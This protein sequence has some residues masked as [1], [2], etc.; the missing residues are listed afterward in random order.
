MLD[1][2]RA[3]LRHHEFRFYANRKLDGERTV[4]EILLRIDSPGRG[5]MITANLMASNVFD[6]RGTQVWPLRCCWDALKW[7]TK[8]WT[9]TLR[10]GDNSLSFGDASLLHDMEEEI[11]QLAGTAPSVIA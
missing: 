6:R 9:V 8:A 4:F 5:G 10:Y 2:L 1:E 7:D 3:K 11:E